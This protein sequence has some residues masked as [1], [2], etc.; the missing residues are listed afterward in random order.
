MDPTPHLVY[1]TATRWALPVGQ[2][3]SMCS[4]YPGGG[5]GGS[6]TGWAWSKCCGARGEQPGP[7]PV[8]G[9]GTKALPW[10]HSFKLQPEAIRKNNE[11]PTYWLH[12]GRTHK[13][14]TDIRDKLYQ[15]ESPELPIHLRPGSPPPLEP[16]NPCADM[17]SN[18]K[19]ISC[20]SASHTTELISLGA[21]TTLRQA[22]ASRNRHPEK[23]QEIPNCKEVQIHRAG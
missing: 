8:P 5:G 19:I 3:V 23:V 7:F 22:F 16:Y 15:E 1:S 2:A 20:I 12:S 4:N 11:L 18:V 9:P 14:H 17:L 6:W 10:A 21:R 13:S